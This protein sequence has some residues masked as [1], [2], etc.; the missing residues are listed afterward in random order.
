MPSGKAAISGAIG[1][2]R[3]LPD[4]VGDP[5]SLLKWKRQGHP[6]PSSAELS[7]LCQEAR[8]ALGRY[9]AF[10]ASTPTPTKTQQD[11]L[12]R[13]ARRGDLDPLKLDVNTRAIFY[14]GRPTRGRRWPNP[15]LPDLII[16]LSPI[17]ERATGKSPRTRDPQNNEFPFFDW[18]ATLFA[19]CREQIPVE[20]TIRDILA[21]PTPRKSRP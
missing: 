3:R 21:R 8:E 6:E 19:D 4:T 17:W 15:F 11:R 18:V 16:E 9:L 2:P 5:Q 13:K 10:R 12:L 1:W 14:R 20:H 7:A